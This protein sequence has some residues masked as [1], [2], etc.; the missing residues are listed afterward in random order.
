MSG[1]CHATQAVRQFAFT[2]YPTL[3]AG[4][5]SAWLG[6]AQR[7]KTFLENLLKLYKVSLSE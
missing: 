5:T 4:L 2:I 1:F 6:S 7:S 3:A